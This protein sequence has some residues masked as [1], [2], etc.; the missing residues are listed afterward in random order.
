MQDFGES[1]NVCDVEWTKV[2]VEG[3]VQKSIVDA[4]KYCAL[5]C[6]GSLGEEG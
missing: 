1:E 5:L 3:I 2:I 6:L 4:E